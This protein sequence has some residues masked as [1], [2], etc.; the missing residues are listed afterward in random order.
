MTIT[1]HQVNDHR[2][3]GQF[4]VVDG[5]IEMSI[6]LLGLRREQI[7]AKLAGQIKA[8]MLPAGVYVRFTANKNELKLLRSGD[9][10]PS[11]NVRDHYSE[12]GLSVADGYHY[13]MTGLPY[14]YLVSGEV[15]GHGSDGEPLL[16][17]DTLEAKSELRTFADDYDGLR[18]MELDAQRAA[19]DHHR[20]TARGS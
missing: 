3:D 17:M 15:V 7:L 10:R 14:Y 8:P 18:A 9:L 1:V 5:N 2:Q 19:P 11:Y 4:R 13:S 12:D 6:F 20:W 16:A